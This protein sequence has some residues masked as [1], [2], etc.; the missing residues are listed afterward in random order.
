[1]QMRIMLQAVVGSYLAL[2]VLQVV[3]LVLMVGGVSTAG[4]YSRRAG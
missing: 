1:M 3:V 2:V 4:L